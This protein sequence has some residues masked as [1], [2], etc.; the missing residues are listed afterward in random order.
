MTKRQNRKGMNMTRLI[1]GLAGTALLLGLF[2]L[3]ARAGEA[4][5]DAPLTMT[6]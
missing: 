1:G 4:D 5:A 3:P 2:A 6:D